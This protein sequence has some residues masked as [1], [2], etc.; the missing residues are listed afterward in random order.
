MVEGARAI[1]EA[2]ETAEGSAICAYVTAGFP[3]LEGFPNSLLSV[4]KAADVVEVGVPFTD[5][6]ADGLTIQQAS[7]VALENG[8]NLEWILEMLRAGSA[9]SQSPI[10]LMGYYNP[11][12]SYG[13]ERFDRTQAVCQR[14]AGTAE[15][16]SILDKPAHGMNITVDGSVGHH[17]F[18]RRPNGEIGCR[19]SAPKGIGDGLPLTG[20]GGRLELGHS[21]F[22]N[23]DRL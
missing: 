9:A 3:T 17:G 18:G 8:V 22:C 21:R 11:I 15:Y 20:R 16:G 13:L 7:H 12:F 10:L 5:P 6:M 19:S 14:S 23:R 4:A 1:T 2:I